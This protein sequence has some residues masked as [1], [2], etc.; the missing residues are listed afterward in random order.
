M[1]FGVQTYQY[2][3]ETHVD[4]QFDGSH[5]LDDPGRYRRLIEIL[6]HLTVTRSNITFVVGVLSTFMHQPKKVH[7]TV[8][9]RILIYVK[10][11]SG[12]GLLYKKY[13]HIHIS[14]YFDS[15]YAGDKGDGKSIIGYC[16]FVRENL[17]T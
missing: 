8:A 4:L 2:S 9:L 17:M 11:S 1:T 3:N 10:S 14:G 16:T 15:D 6:I 7:Q 12:K 13:V 5:T